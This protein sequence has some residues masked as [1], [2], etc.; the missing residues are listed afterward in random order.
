MYFIAIFDINFKTNKEKIE[1]ILR[2]FGLRKIQSNTYIGKLSDNEL[3]SFKNEIKQTIRE[4]DSLL[5]LPI[6]SKCYSKKEDFG[7]V[8]KFEEDLYRVF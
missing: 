1:N 6:C 8:I 7:R 5:F 4:K 3:S 2:H